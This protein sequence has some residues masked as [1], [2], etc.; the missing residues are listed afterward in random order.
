[1]VLQHKGL[2]AI[3]DSAH[4]N[5]ALLQLAHQRLSHCINNNNREFN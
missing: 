1:M 3:L 5:F 2:A 4:L